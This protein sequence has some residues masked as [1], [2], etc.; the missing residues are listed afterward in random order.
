[1]KDKLPL[2]KSFIVG[3]APKT[4]PHG[5]ICPKCGKRNVQF[6]RGQDKCSNCGLVKHTITS[7]VNSNLLSGLKGRRIQFRCLGK[8]GRILL[9]KG[10]LVE[11]THSPGKGPSIVIRN[12]VLNGQYIGLE[13]SCAVRKII[14]LGGPGKERFFTALPISG[15]KLPLP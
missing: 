14:D 5:W 7:F 6:S 10:R 12:T 13:V 11:I 4:I 15:S 3:P 2:E 1:M 8:E 9:I